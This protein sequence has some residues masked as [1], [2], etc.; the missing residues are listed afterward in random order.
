M[1]PI[2]PTAALTPLL[3]ASV[4]KVHRQRDDS[5]RPTEQVADVGRLGMW[6]ENRETIYQF[7]P[8]TRPDAKKVIRP[9]YVAVLTRVFPQPSCMEFRRR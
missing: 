8:A 6:C 3:M 5:V 2:V 1:R 7:G 9:G 4:T